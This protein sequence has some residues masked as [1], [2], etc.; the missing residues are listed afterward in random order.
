MA[1]IALLL[2]LSLVS[3]SPQQMQQVTDVLFGNG[4]ISQSEAAGGLK[5]ALK[6][7]LVEA[8]GLLSREDGYYGNAL[9]RIPWPE[10]AEFVKNAMI[11]LGMQNKVDNVTR[12][13]NRAAEKAA[14]EALDIFLETLR[15][16]TVQDAISI[17]KDGHGAGTEYFKRKSTEQLAERFRPIIDESLGEVNATNIWS[18]TI[19]IY[20]NLPIPGKQPV[21]TDLATFVTAKAM[22]GLFVM[23]EKKENEI[24]DKV[25]AR[26]SGLLQKVFGYADQFKAGN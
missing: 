24:R 10:E 12:S 25:S 8:T 21:E 1:P 9:V 7:G 4:G 16:M 18:N 5:E 15:Q 20:N 23:V 17:V 2:S 3:C 11:A 13:L 14:D 6:L 19:N 26:T 22:D